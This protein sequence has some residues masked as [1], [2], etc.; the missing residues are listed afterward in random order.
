MLL[1][2]RVAREEAAECIQ[3]AQARMKIYCDDRHRTPPA[4][5]VGDFVYVKLGKPG[6]RGRHLDNQTKLSFNKVGPMRETVQKW[7]AERGATWAKVIDKIYV[8]YKRNC[9]RRRTVKELPAGAGRGLGCYRHNRSRPPQ[10]S[11]RRREERR[12]DEKGRGEKRLAIMPWR[13]ENWRTKRSVGDCC[14]R[15][16]SNNYI[17][18]VWSDSYPRYSST[19]GTSQYC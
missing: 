5:K 4:F 3:I 2:C 1:L 14:W 6:K 12:E 18:N 11:L 9:Q 16:R 8:R 10:P 13:T 17:A 19:I 7:T 15:L